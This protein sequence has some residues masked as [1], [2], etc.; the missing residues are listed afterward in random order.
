MNDTPPSVVPGPGEL[1]IR[2]TQVAVS[3]FGGVMPFARRMLVEE[4][5][6]LS[7]EEFTDVLS[8]CQVL[9]GPNIVNVAV[10]VGARY[11]GVRGALAALAG[12]LTAP[13]FII[14][15]LGALYTHYG[16]LPPVAALFRG[17]SATAAGLVV[18]MGLKMA[19]SRRL[20]SAMALFTVVTFIGIALM[21]LPLAV[22][23]LGAA[24]LSIA[25]ALWRSK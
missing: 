11:H 20:R 8:L 12:L 21:R 14:L 22:F 3:G 10:C 24:P 16:H 2:F 19:T 25:A 9:P 18:A 4:R 6:W 7:A 17:V 5:R 1:F 23:L 15:A 13:F